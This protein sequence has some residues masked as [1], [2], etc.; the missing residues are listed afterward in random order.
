MWEYKEFQT[1]AAFDKWMARAERKYRVQVIYVN[2][3][4]YAVEYKPL[5]K[6]M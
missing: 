4:P 5:I 1:K 6:I 3:V 2:N